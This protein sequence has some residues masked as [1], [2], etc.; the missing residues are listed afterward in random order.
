KRSDSRWSG[1]TA[2]PTDRFVWD[3]SP[4]GNGGG[5]P[6]GRSKPSSDGMELRDGTVMILGGSGLVGHAVARRLLE[7]APGRIILVALFENEVKVTA[8]SRDPYRGSTAIE[9]EW[10]DLFLPASLARLERGAVMAD[11]K[12]R[13][14]LVD[15][16]LGELTED[17]LQRSFLYQLL[18]KYRPDAVIDSVNTATAFAYQDAEK[19]A[20]ALLEAAAR[21]Q[22]DRA[23]V[24]RHVLLLTMP[25][26][27]RHV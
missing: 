3:A 13:R 16:M 17:I 7:A 4:R 26:L 15:D 18:A 27:I 22:A 12:H 19:S 10:G 25:Q 11:A 1:C 14:L 24:E 23:T 8:R 5:S 6:Q 20:Q 21:G 2:W 9:V